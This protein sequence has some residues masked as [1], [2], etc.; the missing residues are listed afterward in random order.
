[1]K[2]TQ[3]P[4]NKDISHRRPKDSPSSKSISEQSKKHQKV[5]KKSLNAEF[6][7][8]S[9]DLLNESVMESLNFSTIS[10][11][12]LDSFESSIGAENQSTVTSEEA[13]PHS[14][15]TPL[16][17]VTTVCDESVD[18]SLHRDKKFESKS[19]VEVDVVVN[20]LKQA[21][22]QVISSNDVSDTSKKLLD[23]SVEASMRELCALPDEGDVINALLSKKIR[24]VVV[25]FVVWLIAVT[26]IMIFQRS[27]ARSSSSFN[28][29]PT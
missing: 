3:T 4:R 18:F 7:S 1:M 21:R 28:P 23:A 13:S 2:E 27:E 11:E 19:S 24:I 10:E 5:A 12:S 22:D 20:L 26:T 9:E 17:K 16:S 15:F 8:V 25:C 6:A 29:Y 14:I